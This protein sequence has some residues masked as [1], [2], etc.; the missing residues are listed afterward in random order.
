MDIDY[1]SPDVLCSSETGASSAW[2]NDWHIASLFII[3]G[4][5]ALGV[6]L[7][8]ISRS[9]PRFAFLPGPLLQFGQFFGA[10]VIISTAMIH[11]FPSAHSALTNPCLGDFASQY[12]AWASLFAMMAI[13]TMHSFEWWLFEAW[14]NR[15]AHQRTPMSAI[16]SGNGVDDDSV[17]EPVYPLYAHGFDSPCYTMPPPVLSP[18]INPYVFSSANMTQSLAAGTG[19]PSVYTVRTGFALSRYGNYAALVQS[20]QHLAMMQNDRLSRYISSDPQFPLYTPSMWPM[21]PTG[22]HTS[23]A[24]MHTQ[25]KSTPELMHRMQRSNRTSNVSSSGKPSNSSRAVSLRPNSFTNPLRSIASKTRRSRARK[26]RCL[27]MP[28]LAPTTLEAAVRGALLE[29]L[30]TKRGSGV[31]GYVDSMPQLP[32]RGPSIGL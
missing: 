7:P 30:P 6:F 17:S 18:A 27:S 2:D 31:S 1:S 4:T 32:R 28:R 8:I 16:E 26:Q 12:G 5:S 29:P 15:S 3:I 13:F 19:A 22:M 25:A 9:L 11:I 23:N 10:G 21:P 20:R 14:L 24:A